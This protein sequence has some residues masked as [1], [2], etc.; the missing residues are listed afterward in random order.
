MY[1]MLATS[2]EKRGDHFYGLREAKPDLIG[3]CLFDRIDSELHNQPEL[4]EYSW[5]RSEI[6]NYIVPNKQVL[7]NWARGEIIMFCE[8]LAEQITKFENAL[9]TPW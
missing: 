1:I 3:F 4:I 6:E 5:Q 7:I 2:Q 9:A 8:S